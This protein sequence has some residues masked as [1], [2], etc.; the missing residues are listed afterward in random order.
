MLARFQ[1]R[2]GLTPEQLGL[3]RATLAQQATDKE[4]RRKPKAEEARS[5]DDAQSRGG[6]VKSS[7]PRRSE[8]VERSLLPILTDEQKL[9]LENFKKGRDGTRSA[10]VWVLGPGGAPEA[11]QVRLGLAD[12]RFAEVSGGTLREGELL[13]V[14]S[15]EVGK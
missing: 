9:R 4:N 1:E 2:L 6:E 15:R 13:V 10:V 3:V 7:R 12:S 5:E 8:R 11:R 14:R